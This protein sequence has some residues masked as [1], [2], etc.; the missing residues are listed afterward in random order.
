[1][2][3]R[4]GPTENISR[5]HYLL[6]CDVTAYAEV[7]LPSH[8]LEMGY[9]SPLFYCCKPV[10]LSNDC[11]CGSTV[12]AWSKYATLLSDLSKVL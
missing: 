8:S 10:L 7:C 3:P 12:L 6:L 9:I 5:G 4:H 1:M 11:S 2:N